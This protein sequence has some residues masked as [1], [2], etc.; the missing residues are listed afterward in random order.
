MT[1]EGD[2]ATAAGERMDKT[3]AALRAGLGKMR[4]GRAR[5]EMLEGVVVRCYGTEMPLNQVASVAA[6]DARTLLVTVWDKQN[7]ESVEKA[8]RDSG[9]GLNPALQGALVRVAV[10]PLSE[11]R[12]RELGKI[13][14]REGESARVAARNIRRQVIADIKSKVKE[15]T[16]GED[17]GRA[18]EQK[19]G[20]I[21]D[22]AVAAIDE[23][24]S[25]KQREL[26]GE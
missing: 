25:A 5:A 12:R 8:V 3:L 21:T 14:A 10:P 4:S 2:I 7:A 18:L 19:T 24:V 26:M 16:L 15:K 11:E 9:L 13:A 22:T 17:E 6:S 23:A 20:K 1:G